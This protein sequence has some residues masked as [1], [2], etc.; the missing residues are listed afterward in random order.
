MVQKTL[1]AFFERLDKK[2][3]SRGL[4]FSVRENHYWIQIEIKKKQG[5]AYRRQMN[6]DPNNY[7]SGE[8]EDLKKKSELDREQA[9]KVEHMQ[10]EGILFTA[11]KDDQDS[12][13][14]MMGGGNRDRFEKD[15]GDNLSDVLKKIK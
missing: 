4:K 12:H 1:N 14:L 2:Y 15:D 11:A 7:D 8:E 9:D 10:T 3:G 5:E 13:R 6:Y